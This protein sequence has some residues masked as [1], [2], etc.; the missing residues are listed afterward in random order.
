MTIDGSN[1]KTI[2]VY[3]F[4]KIEL[5]LSSSHWTETL[6]ALLSLFVQTISVH[7]KLHRNKTFLGKKHINQNF[8]F[9]SKLIFIDWSVFSH[10]PFNSACFALPKWNNLNYIFVYFNITVLYNKALFIIFFYMMNDWMFW[11]NVP[12][13][14]VWQCILYPFHTLTGCLLT[15]MYYY[16]LN[17]CV[18]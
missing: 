14:V 3:F 4:H 9:Y 6:T 17:Y 7:V 1:G 12:K 10:G 15:F 11:M 16:F 5:L 8:L 18:I 13:S 2:S